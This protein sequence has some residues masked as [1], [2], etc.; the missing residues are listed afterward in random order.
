M[1]ATQSIRRSGL[2]TLAKALLTST[3]L[4]FAVISAVNPHSHVLPSV[5]ILAQVAST[6]P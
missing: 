4:L 2:T 6:G 1:Y 5:M 3:L